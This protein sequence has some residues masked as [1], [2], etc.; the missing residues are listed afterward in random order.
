MNID[1][2]EAR[3]EINALVAE[4]IMKWKKSGNNWID[5]KT[6]K[7]RAYVDGR[8]LPL[9]Y[10]LESVFVF[11]PAVEIASAWLVVEKLNEQ[12]RWLFILEQIGA[13]GDQNWNAVFWDSDSNVDYSAEAHTVPLAICHAALKTVE[14]K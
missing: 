8:K 14:N 1:E 10:L 9:D 7:W 3:Y 12:K 13:K 11:D 6:D 2:M 4:K 5:A